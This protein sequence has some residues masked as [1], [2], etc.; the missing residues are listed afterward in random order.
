MV[1]EILKLC[2]SNGLWAVLFVFLFLYQIKANTKREQKYVVTIET[3]TEYVGIIK[4][5]GQKLEAINGSIKEVKKMF[6]KKAKA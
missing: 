5:C 3:L 4:G 2:I 6:L 1:D